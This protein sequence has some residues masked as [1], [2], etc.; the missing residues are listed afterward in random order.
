MAWRSE[1]NAA[2]GIDIIID[3]FEKGIADDPYEGIADIRNINILSVPKEATVS[4]SNSAIT[5]PPVVNAI[6]FSVTNASANITVA[7]TSGYYLGM[8]VIINSVSGAFG[9][10]ATSGSNTYY[11]TSLTSTILTVSARVSA[12]ATITMSNNGTGTLSTAQ[13]QTPFDSAYGIQNGS[14][15]VSSGQL[16]QDTFILD[17]SGQLWLIGNGTHGYSLNVL[18]FC[19][20]TNRTALTTAG[21]LGLTI[22]KNYAVL[23]IENKIDT[24]DISFFQGTNAPNGHW[25]PGWQTTTSSKFGH[26]AISATDDAIYFCNSQ[27]V[28]SILQNAGTTFNPADAASFTYNAS[29][30][31]LPT[32]DFAKCLAQLGT[33]LLVGGV[34]NFVYP[35][36]RISTSFNYPLIVADSYIHNIVSTNASAYIFAGN[37]GRMFITNGSNIQL[38]FKFPDQIASTENPYYTWGDAIYFHNQI[39]F[40]ISATTNSGTA[41]SNY[42]GVW[43]L[44]L[45][46]GML[47]PNSPAGALY[48]RNSLSTGSYAGSVPVLL[49]MGNPNALGNAVYVGWIDGSGNGGI[50]YATSGPYTNYEAY[51]DT[52][53]IP[54]GTYFVPE[55]NATIEYKLSKPLVTGESLR[56]AW[57]G[58]LTDSFT[59]VF[60]TDSTNVG[61]VSSASS[62]NFEKQQWVQLR[63]SMSSTNVTPTYNKL[64]EIRIR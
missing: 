23:F 30:L 64:R 5:L 61:S 20:N 55:T 43:S 27:A 58:N 35:W 9:L 50:D 3:G 32:I 1:K 56:I 54:I 8:A 14:I 52:D 44:D 42:A 49:P 59:T 18:Q 36:D 63:I 17:S 48:L 24:I 46:A 12:N 62:V 40:G 21:S 19:G 13:F 33:L 60:T 37:R 22:F 25:N 6:A 31:A 34:L 45:G 47:S 26:K 4:F 51:I 16:V 11:V 7:S 15:S 57:R 38:Y 39:Q 28:G 2:K 53:I 29:A 41:V 10:S